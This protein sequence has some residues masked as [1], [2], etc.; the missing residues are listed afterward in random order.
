MQQYNRVKNQ[1]SDTIVI[2]RVGDFYEAF[3]E[4]AETISRVLE[5]ALFTVFDNLKYLPLALESKKNPT[6]FPTLGGFR[7]E[8]SLLRGAEAFAGSG[9]GGL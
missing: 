5:I 7:A 8:A 1:Y 2:C 6:H 4:D 9:G 3:G